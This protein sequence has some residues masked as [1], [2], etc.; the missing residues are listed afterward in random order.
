MGE[1]DT[2]GMPF[3]GGEIRVRLTPL[4]WRVAHTIRRDRAEGKPT[5][6]WTPS[7][8]MEA[9]ITFMLGKVD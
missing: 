7:P 9:E 8:E 6:T 5:V 1:K 4:G 3:G 2:T